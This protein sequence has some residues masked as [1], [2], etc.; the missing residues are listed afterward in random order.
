MSV[1]L[2]LKDGSTQTLENF[3]W[4]QLAGF[5]VLAFGVL[6]FNEMLVLPILGFNRNT[7]AAKVEREKEED[8][9]FEL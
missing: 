2:Q 9:S 1:P 6:L 3:S 8:S 7:K 5:I 4:M